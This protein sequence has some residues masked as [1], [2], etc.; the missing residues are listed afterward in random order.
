MKEKI[1]KICLLLIKVALL[2]FVADFL[3]TGMPIPNDFKLVPGFFIY[4]VIAGYIYSELKNF[5]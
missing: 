2:G 4:S 5:K 1:T 3:I